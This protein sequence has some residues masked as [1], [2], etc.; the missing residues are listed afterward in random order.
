M[1]DAKRIRVTLVKSPI[2]Y[3]HHQKKIIKTLGLRKMNASVELSDTPSIRGMLNKVP[4]LI[5]I[6]AIEDVQ[7]EG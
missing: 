5:Q 7:A 4:H 1:S 2:G 6:E 3:N